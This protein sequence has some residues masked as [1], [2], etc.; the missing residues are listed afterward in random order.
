VV[1]V[2]VTTQEGS[3]LI[4]EDVIAVVQHSTRLDAAAP[5]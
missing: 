3:T 1:F 5:R 4:D 2:T